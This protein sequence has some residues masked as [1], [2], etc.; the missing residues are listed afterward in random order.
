V[1]VSENCVAGFCSSSCKA[2]A[3]PVWFSNSGSGVDSQW[4]IISERNKNVLLVALRLIQSA[5]LIALRF[6]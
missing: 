2:L 3:T 5:I 6:S 4:Q 1:V